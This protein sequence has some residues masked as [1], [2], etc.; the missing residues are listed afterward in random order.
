LWPI[1]TAL[2][3]KQ[4]VVIAPDL[5]I[6]EVQESDPEAFIAW[7]EERLLAAA[8]KKIRVFNAS[9]ASL[10]QMTEVVESIGGLAGGRA[11]ARVLAG[12]SKLS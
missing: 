10:A 12:K 6:A 11:E 8:G 3:L 9:I 1:S 2:D 4:L 7:A 5:V